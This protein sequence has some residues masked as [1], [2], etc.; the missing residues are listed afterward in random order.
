MRYDTG[1]FGGKLLMSLFIGGK[2]E[3]IKIV[4]VIVRRNE[5]LIK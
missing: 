2:N 1:K 3:W 5:E 4:Y